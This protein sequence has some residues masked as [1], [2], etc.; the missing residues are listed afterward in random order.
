[1]T[2]KIKSTFLTAIAGLVL[3]FVFSFAASST[4]Q[5]QTSAER[6][7][8]ANECAQELGIN[9]GD[10]VGYEINQ[11]T[12]DAH[13]ACVEQK[14]LLNSGTAGPANDDDYLDWLYELFDYLFGGDHEL[15]PGSGQVT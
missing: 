2:N 4:T 15:D 8:Y 6:L 14:V 12:Y 10:R 3:A 11:A 7:Q 13:V 9:P 5:A 1:M